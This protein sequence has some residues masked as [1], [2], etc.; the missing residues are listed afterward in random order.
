MCFK[1]AVYEHP[2]SFLIVEIHHRTSNIK[3][4]SFNLDQVIE[5]DRVSI[6][7]KKIITLSW[8]ENFVFLC[9]HAAGHLWARLKWLIDLAVFYQKHP[10]DWTKV[11]YFTKKHHA[12][13]AL[14]ET[15]ILLKDWFYI[16][17][18][19]FSYSKIQYCLA[20]FRLWCAFYLWAPGDFSKDPQKTYLGRLNGLFCMLLCPNIKSFFS[21]L[22]IRTGKKIKQIF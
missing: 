22:L 6:Q 9:V 5:R 13:L 19:D 3:S 14:L 1:D 11:I 7:N 16:S 2:H 4:L 17:L 18:P 21:Y 8:E 20:R 10:L 12:N 15:K